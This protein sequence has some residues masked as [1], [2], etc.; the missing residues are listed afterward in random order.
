M[1]DI[2]ERLR[3]IERDTTPTL[4]TDLM[5]EAANEI[6]RLR[7][8]LETERRLSFRNQAAQLEAERDALVKAERESCAKIADQLDDMTGREIA[9]NIRARGEA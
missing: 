2:I 5:T 6:E 7:S 4:E 3:G 9:A 1:T 8:E